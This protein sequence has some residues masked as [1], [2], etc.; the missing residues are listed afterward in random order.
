VWLDPVGLWLGQ[1]RD[2]QGGFMRLACYDPETGAEVGDYPAISRALAESQERLAESL[3]RLAESLKRL[4]ESLERVVEE[5]RLRAEA[6][7]TIRALQ[8]QLERLRRPES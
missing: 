1:T 7:T 5:S 8:A 6:E 4:V 2:T 3:E